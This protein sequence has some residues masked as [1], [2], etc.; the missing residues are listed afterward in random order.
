MASGD[1]LFNPGQLNRN[2]GKSK[3][4]YYQIG[5]VIR[6]AIESGQYQPGDLLPSRAELVRCFAVE[7]RT[8][9]AALDLLEQEGV[10]RYEDKEIRV[11]NKSPRT[12]L[13]NSLVYVYWVRS[14]FHISIS[15]GCR[16]FAREVGIEFVSLDVSRSLDHFAAIINRK[17]H[18]I[19]GFVII[20]WDFPDFR[21]VIQQALDR[22][23]KIVFVDHDLP[24]MEVSSVSADHYTGAYKAT[25]HLLERH[26]DRP[27]HYVGSTSAPG[28]CRGR[29]EGW[30]AAMADHGFVDLDAYVCET[31]RTDKELS[32][33]LPDSAEAINLHKTTAMKLFQSVA[34]GPYVI[35]TSADNV[36]RGVYEAARERKLAV[37]RDVFVAGYGDKPFCTKLPVPLTSVF[38]DDEKVG[39]E[40]MRI[41]YN[42]LMGVAS[43][44]V[45][46]VLPVD[47]RIRQS[48][49][50]FS[51]ISPKMANEYTGRN[52]PKNDTAVKSAK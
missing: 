47:L 50:G 28:S 45:H 23:M 20:P 17:E 44:P 12:I 25:T 21:D 27:V 13:N 42:Q 30:A 16:R 52:A 24:G 18:A 3:P 15:E 35:F 19:N 11:A 51:T 49:V 37:G 6:K 2:S 32:G 22:K 4:I 29:Y 9:N 46:R 41:L 1:I 31:P 7:Y 26:H 8:V 38:T 33:A 5:S 14:L 34:S 43:N 40:A 10:I 36:A 48:S 39:Y